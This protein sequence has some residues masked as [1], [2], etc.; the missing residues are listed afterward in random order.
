ML[1]SELR[2]LLT[3][4]KT[5]TR[6]DEKKAGVIYEIPCLDCETVYIGETGK[7]MGKGMLEHRRAVRNGDRTNGVAMHAWEESHRVNWTGAKIR[8]VET[9]LWKRKILEAIHIQT[10]PHTSNLDC[11]LFLND[12]WL[13]FIHN[14]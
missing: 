10:Q 9:H 6:P 5:P 13:P 3:N 7:C 8:E 11:G 4:V 12:V 2:Q 14:K 1:P